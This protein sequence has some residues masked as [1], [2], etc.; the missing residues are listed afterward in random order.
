VG[1]AAATRLK[2]RTADPIVVLSTA[3]AAKF[4]EALVQAAGISC[5]LPE[6]LR[7]LY[8][9]EERASVLPNDGAAVRAFI[10]T[11]LPQS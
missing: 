7:A 6:R 1:L 8:E 4:P 10:E 5:P 9:N 3:H 11:R 2:G